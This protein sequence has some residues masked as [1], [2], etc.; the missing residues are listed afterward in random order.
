MTSRESLRNEPGYIRSYY[1][2][3]A[4]IFCALL[5]ISNIGATKF[6]DFGPIK[7]DGGAFLFPLT[8]ILGD[9]MTE[10]YGYRA[11]RRII[12]TGFGIGILAGLTFWLI[13]ISPAAASWQNQAAFESILGFV[14]QIVTAS[15]VAF[16]LGQL[17]NSWTLVWIKR[18]T[19]GNKLW[20]RLIG[21]T[22]V[23]EFVDTFIFTLIASLGR[24]NFEEFLNY[25]ATGYVYKTLFEVILLPIT[26]RVIAFVKRHE[27]AI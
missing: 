2:I 4:A 1:P 27:N 16:L 25:L 12:F 6:I 22:I 21:S 10:V 18:R 13:Q 8:Y 26:Y 17:S 14:P 20:A 3:I 7:T 11:A 9:V 15:V 19:Q 5:L 24:L 23:G